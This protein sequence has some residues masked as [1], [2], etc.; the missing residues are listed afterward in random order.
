MTSGPK[1]AQTQ[2][3]I[4]PAKADRQFPP[5]HGPDQF[6]IV[7]GVGERRQQIHLCTGLNCRWEDSGSA[8]G[9]DVDQFEPLP[10]TLDWEKLPHY[11][12]DFARASIASSK[13]DFSPT[14]MSQH[15]GTFECG[16]NE[17]RR[18]RLES[19]PARIVPLF[20][21]ASSTRCSQ[22]RCSS[23][24]AAKPSRRRSGK[25]SRSHAITPQRHP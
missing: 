8:N 21:P 6:P 19:S 4:V 10:S 1:I 3:R 14:Q 18:M 15:Q 20:I 24:N 11:R 17:F 25:M 23:K 22:T 2:P 5:D 13:P 16:Q 7:P 9:A 12:R